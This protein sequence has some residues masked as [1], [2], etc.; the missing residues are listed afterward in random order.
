MA[1]LRYKGKTKT[2]WF[3]VTTSTALSKNTLVE[4]VSGLIEGADTDESA[5]NVVGVL[6]KTI[7]ST[8]SD[9]ASSRMVPVIVPVEKHVEW[10]ADGTGTFA[11]TDIGTEFGLS[12]SG[13]VDKAETTTV[14]FK[15]TGFIS[16]SKIIGWIKFNGSY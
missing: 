9:Y 7:A 8:D 12:T 5:I 16:A 1:F 15:M 13:V 6:G 14:C 11:A 4:F 2:E 10:I 3:P